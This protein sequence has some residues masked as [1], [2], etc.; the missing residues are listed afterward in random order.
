MKTPIR[1][2][3]SALILTL[4][5]LSSLPGMSQNQ[6]YSEKSFTAV[7]Y[8]ATAESKLWLC[9]EQYEPKSKVCLQIVDQKGYVLYNETIA[10]KPRKRNAYRQLFDM[11][12][13]GDGKYTFRISAGD[14]KEEFAFKLSTPTL[15]Q[16][17]P[18]RLIAIN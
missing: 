2:I 13:L 8:P 4:S 9:L 17:L 7:M 14:H 15:Q 10:Y 18:T 12:Q 6:Y 11:S 1:L 16:T 3:V 5:V